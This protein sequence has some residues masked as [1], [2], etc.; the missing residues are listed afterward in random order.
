LNPPSTPRSGSERHCCSKAWRLPSAA[1]ATRTTV[2]AES[3]IGLFKNECIR[4]GSPFLDGPL[5]QLADVEKATMDRVH[6]YN[7]ERLHS[8]LAMIPPDEFEQNY[9]AKLDASSD[10]E[11]TSKKTA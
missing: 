10:D 1:S 5:K 3:T 6:W 7:T 11:D 9:Y 8:T 2:L 4:K